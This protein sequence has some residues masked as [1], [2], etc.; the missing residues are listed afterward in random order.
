MKN[1]IVIIF[2]ENIC[3]AS[4][5]PKYVGYGHQMNLR[6]LFIAIPPPPKKTG[7]GL[8]LWMV[9]YDFNSSTTYKTNVLFYQLLHHNIFVFLLY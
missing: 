8:L 3:C 7:E 1:I 4:E 5:P 6:F 2:T 9:S